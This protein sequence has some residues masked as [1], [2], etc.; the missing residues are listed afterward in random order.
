KATAATVTFATSGKSTEFLPE[1]TVLE[2]SERVDVD[3][4]YSCRVGMCGVCAV[5]LLSGEVTMEEDAGLEPED[6]DAGMVLAC[7]AKSTGNVSVEA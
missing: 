3:I 2:A 5:K 4:D 6:R 7:Q 1:E